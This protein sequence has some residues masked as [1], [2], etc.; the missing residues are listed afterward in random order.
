MK[1][2]EELNAI[3]K[4]IETLNNKLSELSDE[5]LLQVSGGINTPADSNS[6]DFVKYCLLILNQMGLYPSE[7]D[8]RFLI[9]QGGSALRHW[10]LKQTNGNKMANLLPILNKDN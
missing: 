4:D 9:S 6:N 7:E 8:V 2:K 10:A 5:E 3:K 1:T